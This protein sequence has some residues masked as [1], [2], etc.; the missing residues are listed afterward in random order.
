[1]IGRRKFF[2]LLGATA[3]ASYL[4]VGQVL[5]CVGPTKQGVFSSKIQGKA[6]D[7]AIIDDPVTSRLGL[8]AAKFWSPGGVTWHVNWDLDN[9]EW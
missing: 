5:S 6:F 4:D 9:K 1:M 2:G 8:E 3:V 7:F